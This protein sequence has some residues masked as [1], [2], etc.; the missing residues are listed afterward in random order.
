MR[1]FEYFLSAGH[2]RDTARRRQ[3]DHKRD[4]IRGETPQHGFPNTPLK[5]EQIH[6]GI[7]ALV[8]ENAV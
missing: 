4:L 8:D 3:H 2:I 7:R 6:D 5:F 1:G